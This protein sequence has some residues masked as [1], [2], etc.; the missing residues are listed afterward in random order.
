MTT[1][2]DDQIQA[3]VLGLLVEP[4][5]DPEKARRILAYM[6]QYKISRERLASALDLTLQQVNT[7][8][9]NLQA[10]GG[11]VVGTAQPQSANTGLIV[12]ALVGA[13]LLLS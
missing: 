5:P 3:V 7:T 12:A 6:A 9:A 1:Q 8:L 11:T 13:F 4:I 2:T 10:R